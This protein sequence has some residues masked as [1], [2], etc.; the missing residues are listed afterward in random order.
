[1]S[2]ENK[3]FCYSDNCCLSGEQMGD[4]CYSQDGK[5]C[6]FFYLFLL[7]SKYFSIHFIYDYLVVEKHTTF[8]NFFYVFFKSGYDIFISLFYSFC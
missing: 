2:K 8:R 7:Y 1:M 5:T 3:I 4:I 6:L